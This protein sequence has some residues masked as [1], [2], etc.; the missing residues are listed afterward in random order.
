MLKIQ[1]LKGNINQSVCRW[2]FDELSIEVL[3][4]LAKEIGLVGIDLLGPSDWPVLKK[5]ELSSTMCNGAEISLEKGWNNKVYHMQIDEGD[6]I[7]TIKDNYQYIAHYHTAG[8][9]GRHEIDDSQELNYPAIMR[10]ILETG[11]NGYVAQEFIPLNPDKAGSLK[12]AVRICD[13]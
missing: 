2:C 8:V 11:F 7:R 5:Y 12:D 4:I 9:P 3:C 10:A 1:S 13:V 6:V